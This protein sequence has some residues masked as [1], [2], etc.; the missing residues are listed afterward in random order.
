MPF[1]GM[2][3]HMYICHHAYVPEY[4]RIEKSNNPKSEL[5]LAKCIWDFYK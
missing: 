5:C 3:T 1:I 4:I 2:Y